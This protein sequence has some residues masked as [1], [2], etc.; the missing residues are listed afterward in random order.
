MKK[1]F[2]TLFAVAL[3]ST[4]AM[5]Q[6]AK[7][8]ASR[9]KIMNEQLTLTPEQESKLTEVFTTQ[10]KEIAATKD[11]QGEEK[12]AARKAAFQKSNKAQM[13]ALTPEQAKKWKEYLAK[14]A[15][16]KKKQ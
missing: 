9:V 16:D 6:P 12:T 13:S 11:L 14:E 8:A 10:A 7:L 3:M 4:V 2:A 15:A 1:I 5:A